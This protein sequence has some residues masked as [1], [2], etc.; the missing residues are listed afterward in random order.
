MALHHFAAGEPRLEGGDRSVGR[1]P[2]VH[3]ID[4][5]PPGKAGRRQ[6]LE[7]A[8]RQRQHDDVG[9]GGLLGRH[10][11]AARRHQFGDE[12]DFLRRPGGRQHHLIAGLDRLPGP[13]PCRP[14]RRRECRSSQPLTHLPQPRPCEFGVDQRLDLGAEQLDRV[15]EVLLRQLPQIHLDELAHMAEAAMQLDDALGDLLGAADEQCPA[16]I[17]L[18]VEMPARRRREAADLAD[19]RHR[20]VPVQIPLILG[21]RRIVADK[22]RARDRDF[23]LVVRNFG[24]LGRPPIELGQGCEARRWPPMMA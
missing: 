2:I 18:L 24:L 22:A 7:P 16:A 6:F 9:G 20:F 14:G 13:A 15:Q 23:H 11:L 4:D 8:E 1:R 10:G 12:R 19:R 17:G 3:R 21:R 5:D